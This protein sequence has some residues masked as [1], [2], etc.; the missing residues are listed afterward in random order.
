MLSGLALCVSLGTVI[1]IQKRTDR[2]EMTKWRRD[3]LTEAV[4]EFIEA[5]ESITENN[6]NFLSDGSV[7]TNYS[8]AS[9]KN[10]VH[11]RNIAKCARR[12]RLCDMK[13]IDEEIETVQSEIIENDLKISNLGSYQVGVTGSYVDQKYALIGKLKRSNRFIKTLE[14]KLKTEIS[15][16]ETSSNQKFNRIKV[17]M[18]I[19][20]S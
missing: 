16:S 5:L 13:S 18:M 7:M 14:S 17:A 10:K 15:L 12:I 11:S 19:S 1:Y 9:E 4:L 6:Y 3:T 8:L 2:R 20:G